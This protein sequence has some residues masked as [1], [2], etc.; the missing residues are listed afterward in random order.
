MNFALSFPIWFKEE[1][2]GGAS[3]CELR[4]HVDKRGET[5]LRDCPHPFW[6]R[7]GKPKP[8]LP[9]HFRLTEECVRE[10][11]AS[12]KSV[13][14][15]GGAGA[16]GTGSIRGM[17]HLSTLSESGF[18][19]WPCHGRSTGP[20]PAHFANPTAWSS[21]PELGWLS[22][23]CVSRSTGVAPSV[24]GSSAPWDRSLRGSPQAGRHLLTCVR[25]P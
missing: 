18:S 12:P 2:L 7:A 16:V 17:P 11:N 24:G 22:L 23:S 20:S 1:Q 8:N 9:E 25:E 13:F 3:I 6:G 19:I 15:I 21:K 14:Q 10:R 5:W 4:T